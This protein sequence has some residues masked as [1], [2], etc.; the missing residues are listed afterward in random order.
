MKHVPV[1]KIEA[2]FHCDMQTFVHTSANVTEIKA[3]KYFVPRELAEHL[4][5]VG[6]LT[7]LPR[8]QKKRA[9]K[10]ATTVA[11]AADAL[12]KKRQNWPSLGITPALIRDRYNAS[13]VFPKASNNR[14]AVAQFLGQYF[15][16]ADLEEFFVVFFQQLIG[17]TPS[18]VVG[19]NNFF[20]PGVESSLDV[21]VCFVI[22]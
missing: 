15:D 17:R 12:L 13:N 19:P 11:D 10:G 3:S 8:I 20:Y 7:R 22:L 6:G 9:T 5:F 18:K 21:Q 14:Q 2:A 16:D 4:D 1:H